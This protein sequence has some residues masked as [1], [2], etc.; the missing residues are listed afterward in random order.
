[1]STSVDALTVLVETAG[2][3]WARALRDDLRVDGRHPAGPWPGTVSEARLRASQLI[4]SRMV[5]LPP[6][7]REQLARLLYAAARGTW[8]TTQERELPEP[9][10]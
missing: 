5:D 8:K 4:A 1:M 6:H 9:E 10:L 7:V 2:T 3:H